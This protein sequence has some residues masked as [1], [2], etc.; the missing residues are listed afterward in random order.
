MLM[1]KM[2]QRFFLILLFALLAVTIVTIE[3]QLRS[4]QIELQATTD[5][6]NSLYDFHSPHSHERGVA[7]KPVASDR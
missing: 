5:V 6:A 4:S 7:P 2:K 1:G 3:F